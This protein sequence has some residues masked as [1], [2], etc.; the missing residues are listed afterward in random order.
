MDSTIEDLIKELESN[1]DAINKMSEE[2][3]CE[4]EKKLNPYGSTIYGDEKYTCLS[5][6]NLREKYMTKLLTTGLIGFTYQMCKEHTV[7]EDSMDVKLDTKDFVTIKEHPDKHNTELKT[8]VFNQVYNEFILKETEKKVKE[9]EEKD[10]EYKESEEDKE[11]LEIEAMNFANDY[12]VNCFKDVESIDLDRM[13]SVRMQLC[14]EQ[15]EAEKKVISKFL[16]KLFKFDPNTHAVNSFSRERQ[17]KDPE[18]VFSRNED[19][20][21]N[22]PNDTYNRFQMYYDVNYDKL[23]EAVMFLYNEKPDIEVALNVYDSFST[24]EECNDF[25][26]KNKS[27]VITSIYTLTNNK[28]NLLGSFKQNRERMNFYNKNTTILENIIKQQED[29]AKTGKELLSKRVKKLKTRNVKRYGKDHPN[30]VKYKQQNLDGVYDT[31]ITKITEDDEGILVESE[32]EISDTGSKID[33]EGVPEDALEIKV[34]SIN[35]ASQEVK[36]STIYTKAQDPDTK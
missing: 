10:E 14:S 17:T 21:N 29:D 15:A 31:T 20:Y 8:K 13:E 6:T 33:S 22:V 18:R 1:P 27:K 25:V 19:I 28:W 16:N 12:L 5:F 9:S 34:T 30:F 2:E 3:L 36:Q 11:K 7:D 24:L 35:A 23:R 26:E 32:V 4:I